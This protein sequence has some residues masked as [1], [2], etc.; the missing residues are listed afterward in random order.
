MFQCTL[1]SRLFSTCCE[2]QHVELQLNCN[3]FPVCRKQLSAWK[4]NPR[5]NCHLKRGV[6]KS[7]N[8]ESGTGAGIQNLEPEPE[9]EPEPEPELKLSNW[10]NWEALKPVLDTRVEIKFKMASSVDSVASVSSRVMVRK[11]ERE[12]KKNGRGRGR[13]EEEMLAR[14]P[15]DSGKRPLIFHGSVHL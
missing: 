6:W 11:S 2:A 14:K 13:G 12:Q 10:V 1:S 8:P 3:F 7:R 9:T 5:G 15:H 4:L